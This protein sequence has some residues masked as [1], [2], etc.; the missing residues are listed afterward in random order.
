MTWLA[1]ASR[2]CSAAMSPV[3][4][5]EASAW[6][7]C[8]PTAIPLGAASAIAATSV[9]GGQIRTPTPPAWGAS[10]A[11]SA[12]AARVPFIF[13]L[14]AASL[15]GAISSSSIRVAPA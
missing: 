13:Q 4:A 9:A 2:S 14:P 1:P 3:W 5:P 6:Q 12:S 11:I 8:P 7:S 10:A 15:R